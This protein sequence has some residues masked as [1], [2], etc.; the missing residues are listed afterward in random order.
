MGLQN[1]AEPHLEAAIRLAPDFL[2]PHYTL[3]MILQR[4]NR[5]AEAQREYQFVVANTSDPAESA[6][7]HNNLGVLLSQRKQPDEAIRQFDAAIR[8]NPNEKNSFLGRGS[9]EYQ[10]GKADAAVQDFRRA[11]QIAPSATTYMWLGS[12]CELKKDESCAVQAYQSALRLNP[13]LPAAQNRLK[14][15]QGTSSAPAN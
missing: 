12:A 4:Q 13:G 5:L 3:G 6:Q 14:I 10:Q 7:S 8:I 11:A 15:L 2:P 9:I 1:Q